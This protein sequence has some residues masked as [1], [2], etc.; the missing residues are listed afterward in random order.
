MSRV[1]VVFTGGTIAMR[2]DAESGGAVPALKGEEILALT[3]ALD[4]IAEVEAIDWGLIPA[5]HLG[6]ERILD[7]ARAVHEALQQPDTVGAVVVHGT[8]TMEETAFALDLL[9]GG[10]EPIVVVGA[11]RNADEDDYDG[12]RNLRNAVAVAAH[13]DARDQGVLVVMAGEI[14]PADDAVKVHAQSL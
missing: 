11:M 5:S 7:L 6:L 8:D 10:P 12:P 13:P 1:A 4:R 3:P 14:L 9:H 2:I